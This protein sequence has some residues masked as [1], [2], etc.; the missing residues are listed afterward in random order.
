M[1]ANPFYTCRRATRSLTMMD[2]MT[3]RARAVFNNLN[4]NKMEALHG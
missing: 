3:V 4:R 1:S 2:T